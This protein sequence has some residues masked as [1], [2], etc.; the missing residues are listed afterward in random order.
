MKSRRAEWIKNL[1][2]FSAALP[3][4]RSSG[5][6]VLDAIRGTQVIIRDDPGA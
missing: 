2:P 1:F 5:V 6:R 4:F 3:H